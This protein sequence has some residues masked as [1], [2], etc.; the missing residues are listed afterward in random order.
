VCGVRAELK[1]RG[2]R[3]VC[4]CVRGRCVLCVVLC[5]FV[6][7]GWCGVCP[8]CAILAVGGGEMSP[9]VDIAGAVAVEVSTRTWVV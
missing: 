8:G 2:V 7:P 4:G 1:G 3:K 9:G 5:G 6:C